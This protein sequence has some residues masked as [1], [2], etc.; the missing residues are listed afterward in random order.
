[1]KISDVGA[2]RLLSLDSKSIMSNS[3]NSGGR[4]PNRHPVEDYDKFE[5]QDG[6]LRQLYTMVMDVHQRYRTDKFQ[7][8]QPRFN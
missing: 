3:W 4:R 6:L 7:D 2:T 8:V 1:M 5:V